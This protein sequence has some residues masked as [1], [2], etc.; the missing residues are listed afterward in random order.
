MR[1]EERRRY[2][3]WLGRV[4]DTL[5]ESV[6]DG[7]LPQSIR[8]EEEAR[9]IAA[10]V[11]GVGVQYLMAG[12]RGSRKGVTSLVDRYLGRLYGCAHMQGDASG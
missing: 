8:V 12:A 10:L 3:E 5:K 9:A 7:E 2:R 11:D 4:G 1:R 6:E